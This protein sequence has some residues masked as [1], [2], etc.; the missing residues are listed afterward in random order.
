MSWLADYRRKTSPSGGPVRLRGRLL[1]RLPL[2]LLVLSFGFFCFAL[3]VSTKPQ[4]KPVENRERVWSVAAA[5][6]AYETYQ[7]RITIFGELRAKREVKLRA[8][9]SGEVVATGDAFEDGAR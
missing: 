3:L 1:A 8:L 9:V 5:K 7:P 4:T 2:P 6:V